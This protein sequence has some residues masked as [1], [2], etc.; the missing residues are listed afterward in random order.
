MMTDENDAT[1]GDVRG[2]DD[3]PHRCR[4]NLKIHEESPVLQPLPPELADFRCPSPPRI[5]NYSDVDWCLNEC[6]LL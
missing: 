3:R 1:C 5:T 2:I 6:V 4:L